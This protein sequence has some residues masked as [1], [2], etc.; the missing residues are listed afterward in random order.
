M[1][2]FYYI[3]RLDVTKEYYSIFLDTM[4]IGAYIHQRYIVRLIHRLTDE[5][6]LRSWV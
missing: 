3:R 5:Y 2:I 4:N 6:N 1:N